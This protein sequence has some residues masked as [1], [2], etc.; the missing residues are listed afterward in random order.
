M[1]GIAFRISRRRGVARGVVMDMDMGMCIMNGDGIILVS[2]VVSR[3]RP[4]TRA[5][6]IAA[7]RCGPRA[8][9]GLSNVCCN[10]QPVLTP[11]LSPPLSRL[12]IRRPRQHRLHRRPLRLHKK[13]LLIHLPPRPL[14]ALNMATPPTHRSVLPIS[15]DPPRTRMHPL[16]RVAL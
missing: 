12:R 2:T 1:A 9:S 10:E 6:A 16:P 14:P 8:R 3:R 4:S 5:C 13:T 11:P 7:D 15:K